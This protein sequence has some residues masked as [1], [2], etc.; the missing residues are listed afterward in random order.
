MPSFRCATC[1]TLVEYG[2]MSE[3]PYRPFCS[4]RCRWIDL[5]NWFDE[6]YRVTQAIEDVPPSPPAASD[7][8]DA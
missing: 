4:Q 3:V 8:T 1:R 5:G 6:E 2:D 7:G